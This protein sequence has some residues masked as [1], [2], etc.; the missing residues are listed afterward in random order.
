MKFLTLILTLFISTSVLAADCTPVDDKK[1]EEKAAEVPA[2]KKHKK[3]EG[4]KV[5]TK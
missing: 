1:V 4:T 5:P 3:Y 2:K